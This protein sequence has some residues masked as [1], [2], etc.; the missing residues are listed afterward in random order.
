[1][2]DARQEAFTAREGDL[3]KY[4]VVAANKVNPFI[5]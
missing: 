4:I 3:G 1:M 2:P 5:H